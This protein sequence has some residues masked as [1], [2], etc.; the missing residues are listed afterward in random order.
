[1]LEVQAVN[2]PGRMA[3]L[4][5]GQQ[6]HITNLIDD[7]GDDTDD[8]ADAV[9]AVAGP[10]SLGQWWSIDLRQFSLRLGAATLH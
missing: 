8:E 9:C 4:T 2:L 5:D 3:L 10:D 1:M 6:L 7:D